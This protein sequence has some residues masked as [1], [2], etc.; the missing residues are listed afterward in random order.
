MKKFEKFGKVLNREDMKNLK[1]GIDQLLPPDDGCME[2]YELDCHK[3]RSPY[4]CCEGLKCEDNATN[5]G[6][7]CV[8]A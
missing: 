3:V 7:I 8:Q 6:T 4:P 2:E 5:T 1:G